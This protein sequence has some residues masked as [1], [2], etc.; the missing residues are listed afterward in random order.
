MKIYNKKTFITGALFLVMGAALLFISI[1]KGFEIKNT[2]LLLLSLAIGAG[3]VIRSLSM[4]L[5][6]RDKLDDLDERNQFILLKTKS[7]SFSPTQLLTAV[8]MMLLLSVGGSLRIP[9][10]TAVGVGFAVCFVITLL[11]EFFT[12][13]Y[14][15]KRN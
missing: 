1:S 4:E 13:L 3:F 8:L 14:Y 15:E 6:R 5:S 10:I 2:I 11:A 7:K 9:E 12:R